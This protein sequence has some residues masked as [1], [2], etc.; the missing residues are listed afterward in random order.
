M[1]CYCHRLDVEVG[2]RAGSG[3][4]LPVRYFY[5]QAVSATGRNFSRS[6]PGRTQFK[7]VIKATFS[8]RGHQNLHSITLWIEMMAHF[9]CGIGCMGVSEKG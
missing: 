2:P 9:L 1:K 5:V 3:L 8:K 4:A 7:V 6:P